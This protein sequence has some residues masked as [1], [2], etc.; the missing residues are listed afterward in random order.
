MFNHQ[1]LLSTYFPS[2]WFAPGDESHLLP[3]ETKPDVE[4]LGGG[5]DVYY[6]KREKRDYQRLDRQQTDEEK[7]QERIELG[8]IEADDVIK[9]I[10]EEKVKA[11]AKK[12][13]VESES[14]D[15]WSIH[16]YE[17][18]LNE[19]LAKLR[20]DILLRNIKENVINQ[21][22]QDEI[23]AALI[24][25]QAD[26]ESAYAAEYQRIIDDDIVFIMSIMSEI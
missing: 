10:I 23:N 20:T 8:I 16:L 14:S 24:Q 12:E 3:E 19:E 9:P 5:S 18:L 22:R 7:K 21:I 1:Y 4:W 6:G 11:L 17:Y 26:M 2:V 25:R 13:N 15:Y